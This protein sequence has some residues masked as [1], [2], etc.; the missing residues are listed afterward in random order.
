MP[1]GHHFLPALRVVLRGRDFRRLFAVR[2]VSQAADGAFQVGLAS[3]IFFS[4][5]RAATAEAAALA[6]TV[7]AL[8]YTLIGPFAGVL[9]DTWPRRQVLLIANAVRAAMVLGVAALVLAG[10]VGPPLYLSALGC[11]SLNRFFLAGL[12]A[13]LPH[14][15]PDEEL[16]LANAVSPTCGTLAAL[17][18]AAGGYGLHRAV[19]E[20]DRGN[21][22]VLLVSAAGYAASALLALRMH[23]ELLGP[24]RRAPLRWRRFGTAASDVLRDL[25]AAGRHLEQR[26]PAAYALGLIGI[27][28]LAYGV[29]TIASLLLCRNHFTD[30]ADVDAGLSLLARVVGLTGVGIALA[31]LTTPPGVRRLGTTRWIAGCVGGAAAVQVLILIHLTVPVLL[32]AALAFG[33]AAQG[34]KICVDAIVQHQVDDEYRGRVFAGYDVVF[35]VAFVASAGLAVLLLPADGWS[36]PVFGGIAVAYALTATGYVLLDRRAPADGSALRLQHEAG[37]TAEV[38]PGTRDDRGRHARLQ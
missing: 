24:D 15:V 16:V 25:A 7:T 35:N 31:A 11:L 26:R 21:A 33:L 22:S 32:A 9:L 27:Q 8:P 13:A 23:R 37:L 10:D 28:R 18:G 36:V 29:V 12:G 34:T 19:G 17:A 2:L 4:A 14:V 6:A 1:P 5:E 20:G 30:P 3:L 38:D